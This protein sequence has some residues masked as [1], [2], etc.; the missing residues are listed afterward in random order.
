MPRNLTKKEET[1][2]ADR[3]ARHWLDGLGELSLQTRGGIVVS[4]PGFEEGIP[5][6]VIRLAGEQAYK[7]AAE[8]GY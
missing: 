6:N 8:E 3:I 5:L 4:R 1:E 2:M 7:I